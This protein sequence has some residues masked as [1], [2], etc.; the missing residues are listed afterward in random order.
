[1][2]FLCQRMCGWFGPVCLFLFSAVPTNCVSQIWQAKS[3]M[4][5]LLA[6]VCIASLIIS[7]SPTGAPEHG[8]LVGMP[9]HGLLL[10]IVAEKC[11]C[12]ERVGDA[13][14]LQSTKNAGVPNYILFPCDRDN[15]GQA[16]TARTIVAARRTT[17]TRPIRDPSIAFLSRVP[18]LLILILTMIL[19]I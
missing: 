4:Q 8:D 12:T 11:S 7:R 15:N 16:A 13:A 5:I 17:T 19:Y 2:C 18:V 3:T 10:L 9:S 6:S 1:M 14:V